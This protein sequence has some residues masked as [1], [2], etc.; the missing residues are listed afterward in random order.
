MPQPPVDVRKYFGQP[1]PHIPEKFPI[2]S[3]TGPRAAWPE[4][5]L[6]GVEVI[7]NF[8]ELVKNYI[9]TLPT[10]PL[11]PDPYHNYPK[12]AVVRSQ[13]PQTFRTAQ[14]LQHALKVL[15]LSVV[16]SVL[17]AYEGGPSGYTVTRR[18]DA[19]GY[20]SDGGEED[21]PV[22]AP[23]DDTKAFNWRFSKSPMGAGDLLLVQ[24]D[25]NKVDLVIRT[26][27][28]SAFAQEDWNEF[29]VTGPFHYNAK[30]KASWWWS[31]QW[32]ACKRLNTRWFAITDWKRWTFGCFSDDQT[33][34]WIS[35]II[36][37]DSRDP[38]VLQA[39]FYWAQS[40][41]GKEG[42]F[43]KVATDVSHLPT[44]FPDTPA[45]RVSVSGKRDYVPRDLKKAKNANESDIE[46][47]DVEE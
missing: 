27:N 2:G 39:L 18:V 25:S 22:N 19:A 16:S 35:P 10:Q 15:P 24:G 12:F 11:Q 4:G 20:E 9:A 33:H 6:K 45:R 14:D 5:T 8:G 28:S 32:G 36:Q 34:A 44:L 40:S 43:Q 26:T 47:S 7:P 42:G 23:R 3:G 1:L 13:L 46:E 41:R 30:S 37:Y 38:T 29:I 31:R 17:T 21:G